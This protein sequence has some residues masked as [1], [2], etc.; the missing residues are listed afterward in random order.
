M[1]K[2]IPLTTFLRFG[3]TTMGYCIHS[4]RTAFVIVCI[5]ESCNFLKIVQGWSTE[6]G[7]DGQSTSLRG[8]LSHRFFQLTAQLGFGLSFTEGQ[9]KKTIDIAH[10][11]VA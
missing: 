2:T 8:G 7:T 9:L 3:V 1:E 5:R 10:C 4:Q 11:R 6:I